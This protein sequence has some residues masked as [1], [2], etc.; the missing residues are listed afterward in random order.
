MQA[1]LCNFFLLA[2]PYC[3]LSA[4]SLVFDVK[5]IKVISGIVPMKTTDTLDNEQVPLNQPFY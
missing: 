5:I 1:N 2:G 3:I 4:L